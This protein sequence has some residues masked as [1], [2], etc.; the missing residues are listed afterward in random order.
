ML[1]AEVYQEMLDVAVV[2]FHSVGNTR[3]ALTPIY[4]IG[5]R[6]KMDPPLNTTI[7]LSLTTRTYS[8]GYSIISSSTKR[9]PAYSS[10]IHK[11]CNL[12]DRTSS[13]QKCS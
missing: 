13:S 12:S 10:K 6:E 3:R 5:V 9:P 2:R 11:S 1:K 4:E 7:I 8:S